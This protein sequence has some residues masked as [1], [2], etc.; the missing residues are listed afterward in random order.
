MKDVGNNF[1]F[2]NV[3]E[4]PDTYFEWADKGNPAFF[5]KQNGNIV[6]NDHSVIDANVPHE[7]RHRV[8]VE[9][10]YTEFEQ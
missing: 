6:V 1:D 9:Y 10:P 8:D 7:L 4:V 3:Y 2:G 5:T